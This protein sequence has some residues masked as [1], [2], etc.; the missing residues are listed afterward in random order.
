MKRGHTELETN[1]SERTIPS[2]VSSRTVTPVSYEARNRDGDKR[3]RAFQTKSEPP[4]R[5]PKRLK[6]DNTQR[7]SCSFRMGN[8]AESTI[9]QSE[10]DR[11]DTSNPQHARRVSQRRKMIATGKAS[12]SYSLYRQKVP[13]EQRQPRS[14]ITPSTP[15]HTLDIPNKRWQGMVRAWRR[16]LHQ[17]DDKENSDKIE[18]NTTKKWEAVPDNAVQQ[19][20]DAQDHELATAQAN[21]LLVDTSSTIERDEIGVNRSSE[22]TMGVL[23]EWD[24]TRR[25]ITNGDDLWSDEDS[26]DDLL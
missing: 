20:V 5:D 6:V 8:G 19:E 12:L 26:D 16:A 25:K 21:G 17:Y 2:G 22:D 10:F 7:S 13:K 23:D 9:E 11:L 4:E 24:V 14:M 3:N 18:T 15:D 1:K